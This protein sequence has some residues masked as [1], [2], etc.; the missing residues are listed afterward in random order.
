MPGPPGVG[1]DSNNLLREKP[2]LD[3]ILS[4][5]FQHISLIARNAFWTEPGNLLKM[6]GFQAGDLKGKKHRGYWQ[7]HVAS[8]SLCT[9]ENDSSKFSSLEKQWMKLLILS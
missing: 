9:C 7:C 2:V 5:L 3:Y 8:S 6:N 1:S 4:H